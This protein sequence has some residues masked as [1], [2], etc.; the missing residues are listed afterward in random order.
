M[1][2]AATDRMPVRVGVIDSGVF[3][4]HPHIG[5]IAGGVSIG[6]DGLNVGGEWIDR[7]GHGT[8]VMAAIQEKAP[9][10]EYFAVRVFHQSLRT[11]AAALSAALNWCIENEMDVINLSLG[12][13]NQA[14]E[15]MFR[16]AVEQAGANGIA[17]VA[18]FEAAGQSCLPGCLDGV[19]GV[20]LDPQCP[21]DRFRVESVA[22]RAVYY[23]SGYPRPV[24][25]VAEER[26][27]N[28]VSFSVANMT[29][30]IVK[31]YQST[32]PLCSTSGR[33]KGLRLALSADNW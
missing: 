30:H 25:G 9:D 11:S 10:A 21:R 28:G 1:S 32:G 33:L 2:S 12:T 8:A 19:F 18:A 17:L 23:T 5:P 7:I 26:N 27:L 31:I 22:G 4:G 16:A 3:P 13:P 15:G 24:P 20:G 29:G 14:H 6:P